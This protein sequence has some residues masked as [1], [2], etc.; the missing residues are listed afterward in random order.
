MADQPEDENILPTGF[1]AVPEQFIADEGLRFLH[2]EVLARLR[3]ETP[4]ADTLE[5][6]CMERVASLYFY[7]RGREMTGGLNNASAYKS[8]MALWVQM[9]TDLRKV[10]RDD[11]NADKIRAEVTG[12]LISAVKDSLK[13]LEPEVAMTVTRRLRQTLAV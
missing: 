11:V 9:A 2:S 7:M 8:I 4:D 3:N 12:D 5:Q 13:G 6:M 10:R 1:W